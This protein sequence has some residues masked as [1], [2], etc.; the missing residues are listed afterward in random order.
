[1]PESRELNLIASWNAATPMWYAPIHFSP[2]DLQQR[3]DDLKKQ[4]AWEA[5]NESLKETVAESRKKGTFEKRSWIDALG[6]AITGANRVLEPRGALQ[7]EAQ[8]LLLAD[9]QLGRVI[10]LGYEPP[11]R[12][13]SVPVYI[14]TKYWQQTIDWDSSTVR[15]GGLTF[16]EVRIVLARTGQ[17]IIDQTANTARKRLE[18]LPPPPGRPSI[19]QHVTAAFS[20]LHADGKIDTNKSALSHFPAVKQWIKENTS[21][22][23]DDLSNEGIRA[24]FAPLFKELRKNRKQ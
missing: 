10:G 23:P 14:P 9:I 4:S 7:R 5:A 6:I 21:R 19:K 24:H 3:W 13:K 16:I 2:P 11:R 17:T 22:D 12:I 1:M 20:A 15:S 18:A 8:A